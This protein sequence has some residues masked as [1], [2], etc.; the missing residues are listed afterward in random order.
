MA[1]MQPPMQSALPE[2]QPQ[3]KVNYRPSEGGLQRCENCE[4]FDGKSGCEIVAGVI[5]PTGVC[6]LF[7]EAAPVDV[8][9][10]TEQMF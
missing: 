8:D 7:E 10:A 6:D 4:H 3:A 5:A 2:Q 9:A 1:N